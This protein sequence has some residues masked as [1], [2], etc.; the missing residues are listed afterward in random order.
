MERNTQQRQAIL[1]V[2]EKI[3]R[4][5][6]VQEVHHLAKRRCRGIGIA[7]VYRNLKSLIEE[8]KLTSIEMPAGVVLYEVPGLAPPPSFFLPELSEGF[9]C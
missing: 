3:D 2:F 9:R 5:L 8:E 4:P 7:T 6:S 1:K